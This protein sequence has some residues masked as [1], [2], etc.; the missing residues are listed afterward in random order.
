[1][2]SAVVKRGRLVEKRVDPLE[3]AVSIA[4]DET[5]WSGWRRAM[6]CWMRWRV[7]LVFVKL[8]PSTGGGA[9]TTEEEEEEVEPVGPPT[10][11]KPS[12]VVEE[13]EEEEEEE[14][15]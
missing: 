15:E 5:N 8:E 3:G 13:E 12:V 1:M 2:P 4:W 7:T 14:P 6:R 10:K 9:T 11:S